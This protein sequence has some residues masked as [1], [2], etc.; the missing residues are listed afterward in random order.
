MEHFDQ[1]RRDL[2][3]NNYPRPFKSKKEE[4]KT[5][6]VLAVRLNE[7]ITA[8]GLKQAELAQRLCIA[9]LGLGLPF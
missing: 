4:L 5:K 3:V 2:S 9:Q 7:R 8:L 6:L 1:A